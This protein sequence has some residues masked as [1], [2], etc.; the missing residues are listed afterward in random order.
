MAH[1][2]GHNLGM[3]HDDKAGCARDGFI[4]SP[5][6]GSTGETE[7][8]KCSAEL[9][10]EGVGHSCLLTEEGQD[11]DGPRLDENLLPGQIWSP[12]AQCQV[13]SSDMFFFEPVGL[14]LFISSPYQQ[15]RRWISKPL[16]G[17]FSGV[18]IQVSEFF[19]AIR[20]KLWAHCS[21]FAK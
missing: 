11:G 14:T 10:K 12:A 8:S 6:R 17:R 19:G 16:H 9:L 7:W 5:T 20:K 1:E 21:T 18:L 13:N 4:M 2:L 3:L 15:N